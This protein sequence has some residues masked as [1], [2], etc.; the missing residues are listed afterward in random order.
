[1]FESFDCIRIISLPTRADRKRDMVAELR[2]MGLEHDPRVTF[3]TGCR[4]TDQGLFDSIGAHGCYL[5]HLA[6][7]KGANGKSVLIL[8][9]DCVFMPAARLYKVPAVDIFYGGFLSASDPAN[10]EVGSIIGSHCMGFSAGAAKIAADYL[11]GLLDPA[12][13][14]DPL[15][16]L[17]GGY[18]SDVRPPIDGAYV[19]FRRAHPELS[20]HFAQTLSAQRPSRSDVTPSKLDQVRGLSSFLG[21]LR[22]VK[23]RWTLLSNSGFRQ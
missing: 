14:P 13:P 7:L 15:A 19:W 8:E 2:R 12:H 18:R 6:A 1:M 9:D 5:S 11:E 17:D 3:L 10:P 16:A 22:W 21:G 20:V 23:S 4:P